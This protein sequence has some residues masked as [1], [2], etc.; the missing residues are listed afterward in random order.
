MAKTIIIMKC[1]HP[2]KTQKAV[3]VAVDVVANAAM[4]S[5]IVI[6]VAVGVAGERPMIITGSTLNGEE[7]KHLYK[8]PLMWGYFYAVLT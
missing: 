7:S 5:A 2:K 8:S 4:A 6:A 1:R 3:A